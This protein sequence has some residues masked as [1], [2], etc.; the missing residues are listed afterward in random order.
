VLIDIRAFEV[1]L[2]PTPT[3]HVGFAVKLVGTD[4]KIFAAWTFEASS[5]AASA[6]AADAFAALDQAFCKA[7]YDFG[8]WMGAAI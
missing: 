2:D 6:G 1:A 4:G 8:V 7:A 5:P 3:A